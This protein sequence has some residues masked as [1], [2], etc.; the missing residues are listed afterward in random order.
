MRSPQFLAL[1]CGSSHLC[2]AHLRMNPNGRCDLL[3]CH[4]E[5]VRFASS[6]PLL[7]LKAIS[8]R[9]ESIA[10]LFKGDPPAGFALPGHLTLAKY[11]RVPQTPL[12]KRDR[13][14]AFEARQNIPYPVAEVAWDSFVLSE[15]SLDF[16]V[17]IGAAKS[18]IVEGLSRYA[19]DAGLEPRSIEP[20]AV[21]LANGFRFNYS[22]V[23]GCALLVDIGAKSTDLALVDGPRLHSRNVP[24]GGA[25]IT[26]EMSE[27]LDLP[28][29]EAEALK[30]AAI[31]GE[32]V[33][34]E[35]YA[36]FADS[37]KSFLRRLGSEI[38]RTTALVERQGFAFLPDRCYLSG[39]GSLLPGIE[40]DVSGRAGLPVERY[41]PL[42]AI[43]IERESQSEAIRANAPFLADAIGLAVGQFLPD[44]FRVNLLPRSLLWQRKF[45]RQQPF[46]LIAA[47]V[48]CGAVALP[49]VNSQL[50]IG[51]YEQEIRNL[52]SQLEPLRGLN[53]DIFDRAQGIDALQDAIVKSSEIASSRANWILLLNDLQARLNTVEDVWLDRL[54]VAR[55]A[56]QAVAP[57]RGH[58]RL[59]APDRPL[60]LEIQGRLLD[61]QNPMSTVSADS[62]QRVKA[63]LESFESSAFVTQ[64]S[65]ERFDN[66]VPGILRFDFVLE[67]SPQKRL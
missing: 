20:S 50:E 46:Y 35:A 59:D 27:A 32:P 12:K 11:L 42:R 39:G 22:D 47:L 26:A 37:T 38:A 61:V 57:G 56:H 36:A 60:Q 41:D 64:L 25:S 7:W 34:A 58:A 29:A 3:E 53:T 13:I 18:D 1:S 63:L 48:A 28:L 54:R 16:D 44:A 45:R 14:I 49:L 19:A 43:H 51:A 30:L 31:A 23:R 6:E 15:D 52:D 65:G 4:V 5:P 21:A 10:T 8:Q 2:A 66:S 40:A 24:F 62:F 67:M 55:N 17:L 33:S 9:F